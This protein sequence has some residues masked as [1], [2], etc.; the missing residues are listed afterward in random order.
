MQS[1]NGGKSGRPVGAVPT[2]FKRKDGLFEYRKNLLEGSERRD[3]L[4]RISRDLSSVTPDVREFL[5][6]PAA[7]SGSMTGLT[8]IRQADE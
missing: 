6:L 1:H 7:D 3:A 2:V 4:A 5:K 8:R